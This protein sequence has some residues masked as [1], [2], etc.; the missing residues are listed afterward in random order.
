ML[1]TTLRDSP[2][3]EMKMF[4]SSRDKNA[5]KL[6]SELRA[7]NV[8]DPGLCFL[9]SEDGA[10]R[11]A[12][13]VC[14]A[15][16]QDTPVGVAAV[17]CTDHKDISAL[18]LTHA[19]AALRERGVPFLIAAGTNEICEGWRD[20]KWMVTLGFVP[21]TLDQDALHYFGVRLIDEA[22]PTYMPVEFPRAMG[23][24]IPECR[25]FGTNKM[26]EEQIAHAMYTTRE[27][28]RWGERAA[29]VIFI[30]ACIVFAVVKRE[31][32]A[33]PAVGIALVMLYRNI[34]TPRKVVAETLAYR[35]KHELNG[36]SDAI[37]FGEN[38]V[39]CFNDGVGQMI[40]GYDRFPIVYVKPT[41]MFLCTGSGT[42]SARGYYLNG[43]APGSREQLLEFIKT[44]NPQ[45][46]FKK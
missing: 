16:S 12:V 8:I 37:F 45:I 38:S 26:S 25:F 40:A 1:V 29:L 39:V 11:G 4:L 31:Y 44:K 18:L 34:F 22:E 30:I 20:S 42:K 10:V 23:L 7:D 15:R 2:V 5:E 17:L 27:R 41:F 24:P 6:F 32:Y 28:R 35:R 9:A 19:G 43:T 13:A 3:S 33:I 14:I 36:S 21:P 46:V